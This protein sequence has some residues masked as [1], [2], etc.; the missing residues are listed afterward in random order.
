[1]ENDLALCDG[2]YD[3][4]KCARVVVFCLVDYRWWQIYVGLFG[5]L[6]MDEFI[7]AQ[8]EAEEIGEEE[9]VCPICGGHAW[10][11]RSSY[12]NHLH[13]GCEGCG[14]MVVE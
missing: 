6:T 10:W 12:N 5:G 14:I 13:C 11:G 4:N 2:A 8:Q 7:K 1:M 3:C 9:F